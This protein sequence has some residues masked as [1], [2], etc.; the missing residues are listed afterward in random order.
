LREA[1]RRI[2][3][4]DNAERIRAAMA[5]IRAAGDDTP[6]NFGFFLVLNEFH[7]LVNAIA[8]KPHVDLVLRAVNIEYWNRLLAAAIDLEQH[9]GKYVANYQRITDALIAGDAR[10]AE[11]IMLYHADW[12]VS[13]LDP[14]VTDGQ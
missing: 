5:A 7:Y 10:S 13:L 8:E 9:A 14:K 3:L 1:A 2:D 4:G 12:C 6:S 11:A